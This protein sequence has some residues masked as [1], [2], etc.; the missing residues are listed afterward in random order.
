[1]NYLKKI[2]ELCKSKEAINKEINNLKLLAVKNQAK[3]KKGDI[4]ELLKEDQFTKNVGEKGIIFCCVVN[5]GY[6][7]KYNFFHYVINK[8]KKDGNTSK[9]NL[10]Y[11]AVKECY[12][13]LPDS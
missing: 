11:S 5:M 2:D 6:C 4:V 8:I 3:F 12:L 7:E 13:K 10:T 9:H 1:M